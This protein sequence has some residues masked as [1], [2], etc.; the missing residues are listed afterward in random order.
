M[1]HTYPEFQIVQ[2]SLS[3]ANGLTTNK[4]IHNRL[5]RDLFAEIVS[6][7]F[8]DTETF[9]G[10][11][12]NFKDL[13]SLCLDYTTLE[14]YVS[15]DVDPKTRRIL[16]AVLCR[17]FIEDRQL[18]VRKYYQELLQGDQTPFELFKMVMKNLNENKL[19]DTIKEVDYL[20]LVRFIYK[21]TPAEIQNIST[22]G[23]VDFARTYSSIPRGDTDLQLFYYDAV[24]TSRATF[25]KLLTHL[26]E[27]AI[28]PAILFGIINRFGHDKLKP[29]E[30]AALLWLCVNSEEKLMVICKSQWMLYEVIAICQY[31]KTAA[32]SDKGTNRSFQDWFLE[33]Y[34]SSTDTV[35]IETITELIERLMGVFIQSV[36]R[37]SN[38]YLC[39]VS[40]LIGFC[41]STE[42]TKQ[43]IIRDVLLNFNSFF[44]N[45]G[46]YLTNAEIIEIR[47]LAAAL[48]VSVSSLV[49]LK[50]REAI[51]ADP[52]SF[53]SPQNPIYFLRFFDEV[54]LEGKELFHPPTAWKNSVSLE[55]V[56]AEL[57][58][59][60]QRIPFK[61]KLYWWMKNKLFGI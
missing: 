54:V 11:S 31:L 27:H 53:C 7:G 48:N 33:K 40:D 47:N 51:K 44:M 28:H 49:P 20:D 22:I 52:V 50:L 58:S 25:D 17:V 21:N 39:K 9:Y 41:P 1:T 10:L 16:L 36:L 18:L 30:L 37:N 3:I 26:T 8:N 15:Y 61:E 12:V 60:Y 19:P 35:P 2:D 59:L 13:F 56:K 34:Q 46:L 42:I 24:V 6:L 55:V 45:G 14:D 43:N 57:P 29:D 32:D 38:V 5:L 4:P 23:V